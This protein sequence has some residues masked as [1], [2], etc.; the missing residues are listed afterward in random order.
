MVHSTT[1]TMISDAD[2][3]TNM[4]GN[5]NNHHHQELDKLFGSTTGKIIEIDPN[6]GGGDGNGD[7]DD[8]EEIED[9]L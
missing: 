8:V 9:C 2:S 6:V 5:P 4:A 1:A 3:G 7:D